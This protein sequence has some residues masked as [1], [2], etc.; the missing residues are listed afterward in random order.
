MSKNHT[1]TQLRAPSRTDMAIFLRMFHEQLRKDAGS[2][3]DYLGLSWDALANL[4]Q[5]I[6]EVRSI[7]ENG[8]TAGF[9]WFEVRGKELHIHGI[10][11]SPRFRGRR[12]GRRVFEGLMREYQGTIDFVELGVQVDNLRAIDLYKSLGFA[13]AD[14]D[15]APGFVIMR[16]A[17]PTRN[18]R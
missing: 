13:V 10:V 11:L 8:S 18:G 16:L 2:A 12:L 9:I 6:G 15:T 1:D 5:S 3:L 14:K 4:F 7:L 17:V